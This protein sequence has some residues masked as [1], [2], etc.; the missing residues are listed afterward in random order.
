MHDHTSAASPGHQLSLPLPE[1][2]NIDAPFDY[3][4]TEGTLGVRPNFALDAVDFIIRTTEGPISAVIAPAAA[5]RHA[6]AV[7]RALLALGRSRP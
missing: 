2:P 3:G 1:K 4:L 7:L 5:R 6:E